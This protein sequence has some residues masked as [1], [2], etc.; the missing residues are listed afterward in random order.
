MIIDLHRM[1]GQP[2]RGVIVLLEIMSSLRDLI[3]M[4]TFFYNPAIPL[5]LKVCS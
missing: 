3:G 5:G 4:W 2:R 1:G